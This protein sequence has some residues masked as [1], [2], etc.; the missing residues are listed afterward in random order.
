MPLSHVFVLR[1]FEDTR[2]SNYGHPS[3]AP[4]SIVRTPA[5]YIQD[6][7]RG[8][9]YFSVSREVI[10]TCS[11]CARARARESLYPLV[12]RQ[13]NWKSAIDGRNFWQVVLLLSFTCVL[14]FYFLREGEYCKK[15]PKKL[16]CNEITEYEK[17][18]RITK[19]TLEQNDFYAKQHRNKLTTEYVTIPI[20]YPV[21][22]SPAY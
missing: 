3:F 22:C 7:S 6:N 8:Q 5:G 21:T 9:F 13:V 16:L 19:T 14:L 15:L 12:S 4:A 18:I 1:R 2:E 20:C 10:C 17:K 11:S